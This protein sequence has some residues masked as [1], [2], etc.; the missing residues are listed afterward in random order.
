MN[1][2]NRI[3]RCL[4]LLALLTSLSPYLS[5]GLAQGTAFSYQGKLNDASGPASGL[6]D[7]RV[8]IYDAVSNG[9]PVAAP[10]TNTAVGVT[11]GIFVI[12]LDFGPGVFSG[13]NRWLELAVR[14][15]GGAG[16]TPLA[17]RQQ[18]LPVP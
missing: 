14:T 15:N 16:F 5:T 18:V 3:V 4:A 6:Y 9:S 2:R 7:L 17:P 13:A 10:L 1:N 11:N 12:T 8:G